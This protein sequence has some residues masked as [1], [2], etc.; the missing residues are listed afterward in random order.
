MTAENQSLRELLRDMLF[1]RATF[2]DLWKKARKSLKD[3]KKFLLDMI[4]RSSQ[5]FSQDAEE[6]DNLK[7]LAARREQGKE[8]STAHMLK[9]KRQIDANDIISLFL[10]GKGKHRYWD[11]LD[12][13]EVRRRNNVKTRYTDKLNLYQQAIDGLRALSKSTNDDPF[14]VMLDYIDVK[15][16]EEF[17]LFTYYNMLSHCIEYTNLFIIR[18]IAGGNKELTL[19]DEMVKIFKA[20][21]DVLNQ[22]FAME[23]KAQMKL[24]TELDGHVHEV[25]QH[26]SALQEIFDEA[27]CDTSHLKKRMGNFD[28][29]TTENYKTFLQILEQRMNDLVAKIYCAERDNN[30]VNLL[31]E[32]NEFVI[33]SL[34]REDSPIV[35]VDELIKTQQ[36]PECSELED[37]NP[38]DDKFEDILEGDALR[39]MVEQN[40]KRPELIDRMHNLSACKLPRS[41]IVASKRYAKWCEIDWIIFFC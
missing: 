39:E 16:N 34:K 10:K 28:R 29:I 3:R 14:E 18:T 27:Q 4:E 33:S 30:E 19:H 40:L 1:A 38:Y 6:L 2:N 24:Q 32:D 11:S 41:G 25:N 7:K 13:R 31:T 9:M 5:A 15:K 35:K 8:T 21:I 17:Q 36:C 12:E 22:S 37:F 20:K 23:L 26:L